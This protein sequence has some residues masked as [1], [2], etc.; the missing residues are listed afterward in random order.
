MSFNINRGLVEAYQQVNLNEVK[1]LQEFKT[2]LLEEFTNQGYELTEED[3]EQVLLDEGI[4]SLAKPLLNLFKGAGGIAKQAV[5]NPRMRAAAQRF[6]QQAGPTVGKVLQRTG[7]AIGDVYTASKPT[8]KK[9]VKAATSP[10]GLKTIGALSGIEA[11]T[12]LATGVPSATLSALGAGVGGAGNIVKYG[13]GKPMSALGFPATEK[14]GDVIKSLGKGIQDF[15]QRNKGKTTSPTTTP[16]QRF[17]Y[18]AQGRITGF[19][20]DS[21]VD[22]EN[23]LV[24]VLINDGL[25]SNQNESIE[26][27]NQVVEYISEAQELVFQN[28]KPG[29]MV[30]KDG[31]KTWRE[32]DPKKFPNYKEME[33]SYIQRRG[34]GQIK[35]DIST[36]QQMA[37][38]QAKAREDKKKQQQSQ[39]QQQK[40]EQQK[41]TEQKPEDSKKEPT[42]PAP[43]PKAPILAK[44][45]GVTGEM[46]AEGKFKAKEWSA[47]E[48]ERYETRRGAEQLK[49]DAETVAKI[50]SDRTQT[51]TKPEAKVE[52]TPAKEQPKTLEDLRKASA[53][54][55]MTGPSK[56]AQELMS[57]KTKRLLGKEKLEAGIKAQKEVESMKNKMEGY[58]AFDNIKDF[59]IYGGYAQN[60]SEAMTIMVSMNEEWKN[61]ILELF[62]E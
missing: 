58:D 29:I 16:T 61:Y 39:Q 50:Q 6:T 43:K 56:E 46:D 47:A 32:I 48:K 60:V 54:A 44:E 37:S 10:T 33:A 5:T 11:A 59:L 27:L 21:D 7:K 52:P 9:V 42:P 2:Y 15:N 8:V 35:Q 23:Y 24:E 51:E 38:A 36:A 57:D 17:E 28:N 30:T 12:S 18:D 31:K 14:I 53:K 19:K 22:L 26:L 40:P 13:A 34:A 1:V 3:L 55:T 49:K 25:A 20:E 41:P 62:N 4:A 45:K